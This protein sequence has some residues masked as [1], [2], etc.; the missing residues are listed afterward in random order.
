PA[1]DLAF[2]A[3]AEDGR[4][5]GSV[6]LWNVV[7]GSAGPALLLGPI[8]VEEHL[9]NHGIGSALMEPA[10]SAAKA[11]GH[12]AIILV[13]DEPYYRRFGFARAAVADLRLPGPVDRDRFLGLELVT[14]ALAAAAGVVTASGRRI[15]PA[16]R[17]AARSFG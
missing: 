9:R 6:R 8:A 13:G 4:L 2:S 15:E 11:Q 1:E 14:D 16:P 12:R 10:L 3:H 7:A 5:V 17:K